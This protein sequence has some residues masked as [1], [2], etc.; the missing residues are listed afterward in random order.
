MINRTRFVIAEGISTTEIPDTI[1]VSSTTDWQAAFGFSSANTGES[2]DDDL[3]FDPW[4]ESTK[5]LAD[6]I[7][8]ENYSSAS[9]HLHDQ[10]MKNLPPGF[11]PNHIGAYGHMP[12]PGAYGILPTGLFAK[13]QI[14][15]A[16][17]SVE[18][19]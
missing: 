10:R 13:T 19:L 2:H 15:F 14:I 6:L 5:A 9:Q 7:E 4:D 17:F 18:G 16:S 12:R 8:K 11:A 3:G 1:P